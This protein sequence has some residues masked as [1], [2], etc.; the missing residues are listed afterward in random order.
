[1]LLKLDDPVCLNFL[2][3]VFNS[4]NDVTS[5]LFMVLKEEPNMAQHPSLIRR[6]RFYLDLIVDLTRI[7]ETVSFWCP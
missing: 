3:S 6:S 2:N 7:L 5:E 1:M 4:L